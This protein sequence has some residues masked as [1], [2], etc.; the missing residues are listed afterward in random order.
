[1]QE[2]SLSKK[3]DP[4][5][6]Y[7]YWNSGIPD[8][9][10]LP[11]K[12]KRNLSFACIM[13]N[14]LYR[15]LQWE[16]ELLLLTAKSWKEEINKFKPQLLL[17]ESCWET[18]TGDWI[19]AQLSSNEEW[20]G[21]GDIITYFRR[22][23]IPSVFW[24]TQDNAY[25]PHYKKFA[26]LFDYVFC[27]DQ[28]GV[29]LLRRDGI[30]A[31]LLLPGIQPLIYNPFRHYDHY[32]ALEIGALLDGWNDVDR[33][34]EEYSCL[35][36]LTASELLIIDSRATIFKNRL[37]LLGKLQAHVGGCIS[38]RERTIAL[39]YAKCYL[40]M[41]PTS[42]TPTRR[43]KMDLEAMACRT[44]V[45]IKGKLT[46]ADPR[47]G[48]VHEFDQDI[49]FLTDI[50][51]YQ[52]DRLY[53][54]RIAQKAWR[55]VNL[56]HTMS[57]RINSICKAVGIDNNWDE[58]PLITII[59]PTYRKNYL[60]KCIDQYDRQTYPAKELIL[61]YNG[62][63]KPKLPKAARE[64]SDIHIFYLPG[65]FFTGAAMN[66]GAQA[67]KG[68]YC[69]K[70]DDDDLYGDNYILDM[71]LHA[72]PINADIF[73]KPLTRY[74]HFESDDTIYRS[75]SKKRQLCIV[76]WFHSD[77]VT[78]SW[79]VGCSISGKTEIFR[80]YRYSPN[81]YRCSDTSFFLNAA[82]SDAKALVVDELNM[83]VERR[84]NIESHTW[85]MEEEDLKK[86]ADFI[87]YGKNNM[88]I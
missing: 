54:E 23:G 87:C 79:F 80:K 15:S 70:V 43:L 42:A 71:M 58:F 52:N 39:K 38:E 72:S 35:E 66:L 84:N 40:S 33:F 19:M 5:S 75:R 50:A 16:A 44:P 3:N 12:P 6:H 59:T 85:K 51:R 34:R 13:S 65:E 61:I 8:F 9:N 88:F 41:E 2:M 48:F 68:A 31:R 81:G 7:K 10:Y 46:S 14:S 20:N 17:V 29:D 86:Y 60:E 45:I 76:P 67:A 25:H 37:K 77:Y 21:L 30:N 28:I 32:D 47:K 24:M 36:E 56:R 27:V 63:D 4:K 22:K 11:L 83:L 82:L 64:R 26:A 62:D 49:D 57:H 73:G 78:P 74:I 55:E 1:M 18:A 69:F 53:R